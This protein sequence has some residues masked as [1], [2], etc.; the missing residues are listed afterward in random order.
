MRKRN[1]SQTVNGSSCASV[2]ADILREMVLM[3]AELRIIMG[4]DV[5]RMAEKYNLNV[6]EIAVNAIQNELHVA[7]CVYEPWEKYGR[8]RINLDEKTNGMN[9]DG[10][11]NSV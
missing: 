3:S 7:A 10:K 9:L 4:D 8:E 11:R 6:R 1:C 2:L 5:V